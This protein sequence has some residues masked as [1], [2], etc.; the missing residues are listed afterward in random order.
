MNPARSFQRHGLRWKFPDNFS[1]FVEYEKSDEQWAVPLGYGRWVEDEDSFVA[2]KV[3]YSKLPPIFGFK[4][5]SEPVIYAHPDVVDK[6]REAVAE[7]ISEQVAREVFGKSEP[8]QKE[9]EL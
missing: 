5:K 4:V 1:P 8:K 2:W 3:D 7:R 9:V 6:M